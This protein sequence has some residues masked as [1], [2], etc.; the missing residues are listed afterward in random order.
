M[1][2]ARVFH[3]TDHRHD[4]PASTHTRAT[5]RLRFSLRE[6][7]TVPL[8]GDGRR[9]WCRHITGGWLNT[10]DGSGRRRSLRALPLVGRAA[11]LRVQVPAGA[12]GRGSADLPAGP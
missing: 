3:R 9:P 7:F 8:C 6:R 10:A 12:H 2:A 11:V 5:R 4:S 1:G